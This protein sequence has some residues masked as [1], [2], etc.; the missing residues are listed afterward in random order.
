MRTPYTPE[1]VEDIFNEVLELLV[2]TDDTLKKIINSD[3]RYPSLSSFL[4][5]VAKSE[6]KKQVYNYAIEI[7]AQVIFSNLMDI[8]KGD[9]SRPDSLVSIQRD[10]LIIDTGKFAIAKMLPK[11]Y[12]DRVDI[13]TNGQSI[14]VINLGQ[15]IAPPDSLIDITPPT[16]LIAETKSGL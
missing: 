9:A 11:L 4:I 10:R 1:E 8:A 5:W 16:P 15:G 13:T 3:D 14:N 7:K 2:T 12:G 6:E